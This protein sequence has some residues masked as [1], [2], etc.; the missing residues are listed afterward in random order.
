MLIS[1]F[2]NNNAEDR[3]TELEEQYGISLP[4]QYR[5]FLCKYN[6]GN[7]PDTGYKAGRSSTDVRGFYGFGDVEFSLDKIGLDEWLQENIFPIACDAF[8][9]EI[10][11]ALD[12]ESYGKIYFCD[13]EE[14][15]SRVLVGDD[16][17]TFVQKCKSKKIDPDTRMP[18]EEREARLIERGRGHVITEGL[19]KMWQA[20]IDKYG[21]MVQE[22]VI[23][24]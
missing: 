21:N 15:F 22:R 3:I 14:G 4:Y 7:T 23:F 10:V 24:K 17:K 13:H 11:I 16:F 9:N 1:R 2:P 20:E 8:G 6:G 18:I 19:R 12:D 5:E